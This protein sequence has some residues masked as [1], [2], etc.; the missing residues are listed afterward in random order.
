M[1]PVFAGLPAGSGRPRPD[2]AAGADLLCGQGHSD[3]RD[4]GFA[5]G[6]CGRRGGRHPVPDLPPRGARARDRLGAWAEVTLLFFFM[7]HRIGFD[8]RPLGRTVAFAVPGATLTAAAALAVDRVI[9]GLTHGSASPPILVAEPLA[10]VAWQDGC[11][12]CLERVL[13][14]CQQLTAA[15]DSSEVAAAAAADAL[16]ATGHRLVR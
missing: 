13:G 12:S 9:G 16:A 15:T 8:L 6:G 10:R 5:G 2:F 14:V 1:T 11:V 7:R 3:A 4:C